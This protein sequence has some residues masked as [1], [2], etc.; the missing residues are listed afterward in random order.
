[1]FIIKK[2]ILRKQAELH[3]FESI[4]IKNVLKQ[5]VKVIGFSYVVIPLCS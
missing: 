5:I 3:T 4:Q 1:V 2:Q